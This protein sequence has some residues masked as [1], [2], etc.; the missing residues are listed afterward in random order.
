M[1]EG[2]KAESKSSLM[3]LQSMMRVMVRNRTSDDAMEGLF[4]FPFLRRLLNLHQSFDLSD[5]TAII[6][7]VA[8]L[9]LRSFMGQMLEHAS[10]QQYSCTLSCLR[11]KLWRCRKTT[12]CRRGARLACR[13]RAV[14]GQ[15]C[16]FRFGAALHEVT[17]CRRKGRCD[18]GQLHI[19]RPPTRGFGL[20]ASEQLGSYLHMP[21][22][23]SP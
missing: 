12:T 23:T 7:D 20:L 22:N 8:L 6:R 19:C 11:L 3:C 17:Q 16:S 14:P 1:V 10:Y 21:I 4:D 2:S 13:G 5:N 9:M 18:S 15:F